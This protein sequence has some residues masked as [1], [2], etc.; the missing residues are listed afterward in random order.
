MSLVA[1]GTPT[2]VSTVND[3]INSEYI[4]RMARDAARAPLVGELIIKPVVLPPEATSYTYQVPIVDTMTGAAVVAVPNAAPEAALSTSVVTITGSRR[5]IRSFLPDAVARVTTIDSFN[6]TVRNLSYALRADIE[7]DVLAI[8]TSI[9]ATQGDNATTNDLANWDTATTAFRAL[10]HDAGTLYAVLHPDQ[11]AEL[12]T[13]LATNA[14]ALFGSSF[15]DRAHAA[16]A[17]TTPGLGTPFDG[18]TI[19]ESSR[20]P[21]GDTTGH[22]GALVVGGDL[23]AIEMPVWIGMTGA[24]QRDE[25]RWGTW[26]VL[27]VVMGVGLVKDDNAYAIVSEAA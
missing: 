24:T 19:L 6:S 3:A 17:N 25:S 22:T 16:L 4:T 21:A 11:I 1:P 10:N 12:R 15:G 20:V 18:Y 7:E 23:A 9:T 13:D 14:A 26:I 5:G 2:T 8:F 27:G